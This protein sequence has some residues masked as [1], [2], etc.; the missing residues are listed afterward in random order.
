METDF[1]KI[2]IVDYSE[3]SI[4]ILGKTYEIKE[5]LK[6]AHASYNK[7]L[8]IDNKIVWGWIA[9]KKQRE[10]IEDII[11][12]YLKSNHSFTQ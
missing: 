3:K 7:H 5:E 12:Q 4:A 8:R 9:S 6:K 2:R 11:N 1:T 10:K